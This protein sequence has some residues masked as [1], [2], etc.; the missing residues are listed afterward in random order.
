[1]ETKTKSMCCF[2][3]HIT[4]EG[5]EKQQKKLFEIIEDLIVN[6]RIHNF[7]Y[8]GINN[9]NSECH[10]IICILSKKYPYVNYET[11]GI[12]GNNFEVFK[13]M[14]DKCDYCVFYCY[15]KLEDKYKGHVNFAYDYAIKNNK[16]VINI[17]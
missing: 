12:H 3:G 17:Y 11:I 14:I 15:D 10:V 4:Y 8:G 7:L 5:N 6:K 1:M 16:K 9:F 2:I 13:A